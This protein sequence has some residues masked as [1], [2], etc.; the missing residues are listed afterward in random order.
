M[1]TPNRIL[2]DPAYVFPDWTTEEP[3]RRSR[4]LI[5][6]FLAAALAL[7]LLVSQEA[8]YVFDESRHINIVTPEDGYYW[9]RSTRAWMNAQEI[10]RFYK[11]PVDNVFSALKIQAAPGDEKITLQ[12]LAE[13][14]NKS[15]AEVREALNYLNNLQPRRGGRTY[16]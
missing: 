6:P 16:R 1:Q 9:G 10:S 4:I 3:I 13:K 11:V 12:D 8:Y 5:L 14:Y 7:L 2:Y 15:P